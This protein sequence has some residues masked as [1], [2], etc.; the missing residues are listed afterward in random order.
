MMKETGGKPKHS[1][2]REEA[3]GEFKQ[4]KKCLPIIKFPCLLTGRVKRGRGKPLE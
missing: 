2:M 1:R 3:V 4:K